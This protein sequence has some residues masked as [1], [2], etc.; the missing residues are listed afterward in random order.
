MKKIILLSIVIFLFA[1]VYSHSAITIDSCT[2]SGGVATVKG[3]GFTS[4]GFTVDVSRMSY[5]KPN[6]DAGNDSGVLFNTTHSLSKWSVSSGNEPVYDTSTKYFGNASA[7]FSFEGSVYDSVMRFDP[8]AT[9]SSMYVESMIKF[10]SQQ[11]GASCNF[12][13]KLAC[14]KSN[15][16]DNCGGPENGTVFW[17]VDPWYDVPT[18]NMWMAI[19]N[20]YSL[21][22]DTGPTS[23][24]GNCYDNSAS[25]SSFPNNT[26][27]HWS[28]YW[29]DSSSRGAADGKYSTVV[30]HPGTGISFSQFKSSCQMSVSNSP[31]MRYL[32]MGSFAG[33]VDSCDGGS[34]GRNIHIWWDATLV[35]YSNGRANAG[36]I[37]GDSSGVD[38]NRKIKVT[39]LPEY[40]TDTEIR[41]A[42]VKGPLPDGK[43]YV[44][45][46]NPEG[47]VATKEITLGNGEE[48]T[49]TA[50]L[51]LTNAATTGNPATVA[52][53]GNKSFSVVASFDH[54]VTCT[55][56]D[57]WTQDGDGG[58]CAWTNITANKSATC[59]GVA[60]KHLLLR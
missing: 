49:Y 50:E 54:K 31:Y 38:A 23:E 39:Q 37:D 51:S 56:C 12:Q 18:G 24:D 25:Y 26:W 19:L 59:T 13:W 30:L 16:N 3:S 46:E 42:V 60:K 29:Q 5:L 35:S 21:S 36:I 34:T 57:T 10:Y 44:R 52:S 47:E 28:M 53:G 45:I 20:A 17:I 40:W 43:A 2:V 58:T 33:N 48:E 8:G 1:S 9:I 14:T 11:T 27:L 15:N 22:G 4:S 32:N 55:G 41:F 7:K 6:L